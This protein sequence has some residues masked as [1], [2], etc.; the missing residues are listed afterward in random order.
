MNIK[1]AQLASFCQNP[2]PE[3]KCII[4]FGTN[5]GLI[6]EWQNK[7]ATAVCEDTNDGFRYTAFEMEQISATGGELYGEYHAQSLMGGRRVVVVKNADNSLYSVLKSMLP[8]TKSENLLIISSSS[9][10]TR[11]SL[12]SWAKERDD[13]YVVGCYDDREADISQSVA[14]MLKERGLQ[15]MPD[16]LQF[17]T[18][19]LSS[20]RKMNVAEIDKLALYLGDKKTVEIADI[21]AAVSDI[22]GADYE[23]LCYYIASGNTQKACTS[24]NR[25]IKEGE[26]PATLIR[27]IGYHFM[28]LLSI[29]ALITEGKSTEEA[30]KS[31]R[32]PLMFYRK[33]EFIRQLKVWNKDRIFSAL[34]MLYECERDCKTTGMPAEN[35]AD[36]CILRISGA[37][38]KFH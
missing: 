10:N 14:Q 17:L 35:L 27:Q 1:P 6:N 32:P 13:I 12:I 29:L 18:S 7:C 30:L 23:D 4:L 28:K 19:R 25:L 15:T 31:L 38:K 2:N 11:S 24:F 8:E 20:D 26:E 21:K 34:S 22:A 5:E 37:V 9:L 33:D 3:I 36:Y 16:V